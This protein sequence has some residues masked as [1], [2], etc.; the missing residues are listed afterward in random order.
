MSTISQFPSADQNTTVMGSG[1][2]LWN[3]CSF[4]ENQEPNSMSE[5]DVSMISTSS[6]M[7]RVDENDCNTSFDTHDQQSS[8]NGV[9]SSAHA[10]YQMQLEVRIKRMKWSEF[11]RMKCSIVDL[12]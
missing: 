2:R 10:N 6:T 12:V 4:D 3:Q 8:G 5:G 7:Q 9:N 1:T 11:D